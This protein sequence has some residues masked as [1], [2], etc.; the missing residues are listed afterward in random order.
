MQ[1]PDGRIALCLTSGDSSVAMAAGSSFLNTTGTST[2][3]EVTMSTILPAITSAFEGTIPC[4]PT[5][6]KGT[7]GH[8][9]RAKPLNSNG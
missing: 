7:P 3:L 9:F 4:H 8:R 1:K 2:N 5:K 6:P